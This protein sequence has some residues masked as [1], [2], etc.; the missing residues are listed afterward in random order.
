MKFQVRLRAI[1]KG[2]EVAK[3]NKSK[4]EEIIRAICNI[5]NNNTD[6]N[7]NLLMNLQA[8]LDKLYIIKAK[9]TFVR[10]RR[11]WLEEGETNSRYFYNLEKRN[12]EYTSKA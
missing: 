5:T 3:S 8:E 12:G 11:R 7:S 9:G 6:G 2:K 1:D 10:S 4:E